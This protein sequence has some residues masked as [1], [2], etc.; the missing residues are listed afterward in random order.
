[1]SVAITALNWRSVVIAATRLTAATMNNSAWMIET[2]AS[3]GGHLYR[4]WITSAAWTS[5]PARSSASSG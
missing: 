4:R 1:V 2:L 3:I 5:A